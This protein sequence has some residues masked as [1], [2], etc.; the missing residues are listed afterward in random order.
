MTRCCQRNSKLM[1]WSLRNLLS[2][3]AFTLHLNLEPELKQ[4]L[5]Q[6]RDQLYD[7][8]Y[9]NRIQEWWRSEREWWEAKGQNWTQQL[10]NVM[11]KYRNIGHNWIFSEQQKSLLRKYYDANK[12]LV[13]CLNSGCVMYLL[14]CGRKSRRHCCCRSQISKKLVTSAIARS[15]STSYLLRY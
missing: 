13:D 11:I 4:S 3:L 1:D 15:N 10:I 12:L 8:A 6:L 9:T 5:Q 2:I 7:S 14:L